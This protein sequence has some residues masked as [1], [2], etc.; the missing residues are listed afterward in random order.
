METARAMKN[1]QAADSY[2]PGQ[3]SQKAY[4]GEI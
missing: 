3:S 2:Y 4:K 1:T